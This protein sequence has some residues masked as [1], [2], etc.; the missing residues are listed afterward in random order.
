MAGVV[1][2]YLP[3]GDVYDLGSVSEALLVAAPSNFIAAD[4]DRARWVLVVEKEVRLVVNGDGQSD[5]RRQHSRP[6]WNRQCGN[7]A[8]EEM[9]SCLR[10]VYYTE[11][12]NTFPLTRCRAKDIRIY[13]RGRW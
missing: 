10:F 9:A 11:Q 12:S 6:S 2:F 1:K 7:R 5:V 4:V 13:R 3:Q 8:S